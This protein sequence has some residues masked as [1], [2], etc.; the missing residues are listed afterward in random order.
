[1]IA[2]R[3]RFR[4]GA[5][6]KMRRLLADIREAMTWRFTIYCIVVVCGAGYIAYAVA[7]TPEPVCWHG[8]ILG[9]T[10]ACR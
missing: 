4:S 9:S 2:S 7:N 5:I 1:M 10:E 6:G 3:K 8:M